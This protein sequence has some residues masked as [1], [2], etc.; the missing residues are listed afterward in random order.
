M[1]LWLKICTRAIWLCNPAN[2]HIFIPAFDDALVEKIRDLPEVGKA[3][4]R[5]DM[6]LRYRNANGEWDRLQVLAIPEIDEMAIDRIK[7]LEG[8]W[9]PAYREIAIDVNQA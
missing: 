7:P 2:L 4:G 6:T 3:E 8:T 9:P 1:K 5:R